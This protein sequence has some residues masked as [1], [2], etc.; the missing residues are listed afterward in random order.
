MD[1]KMERMGGDEE[2]QRQA[3][4][5]ENDP[6]HRTT[7]NDMNHET[8]TAPILY[9]SDPFASPPPTALPNHFNHSIRTLYY[10]VTPLSITY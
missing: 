3:S 6:I 5:C 8:R 2:K 7:G 4:P 1:G 9:P 10:K